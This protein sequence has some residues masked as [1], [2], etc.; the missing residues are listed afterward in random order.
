MVDNTI[1]YFKSRSKT[2]AN[3]DDKDDEEEED[4]DFEEPNEMPWKGCFNVTVATVGAAPTA[5]SSKAKV[6]Q[7]KTPLRTFIIKARHEVDAEEWMAHICAAQQGIPVDQREHKLR[8]FDV[9]ND[10]LANKL[11]ESPDSITLPEILKHPV[12]VRVF[13]QFL[14]TSDA[15]LA[16]SV[17]L[18]K[19]VVKYKSKV[20]VKGRAC[21]C[22]GRACGGERVWS[23]GWLDGLAT[24]SLFT[25]PLLSC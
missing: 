18:F 23:C 15:K 20:S 5:I 3:Y 10:S 11:K 21:G 9:Y 12:G 8:G 14:A 2:K 25:L 4:D 19:A 1:Y 6:F 16:K 17:K 7:I 22:V 24:P 13:M